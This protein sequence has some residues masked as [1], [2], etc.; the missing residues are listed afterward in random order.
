MGLRTKANFPYLGK[1]E[2]SRCW[3][4]RGART[5][6]P[7]VTDAGNDDGQGD[8]DHHSCL[9]ETLWPGQLPT[10]PAESSY[11][12]SPRLRWAF[13]DRAAFELNVVL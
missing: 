2:L 11:V 4:S 10:N 3:S 1:L 7:K 9:E 6:L 13:G 5:Q 12:L 8:S